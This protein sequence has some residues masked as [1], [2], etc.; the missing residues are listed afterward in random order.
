VRNLLHLV[1]VWGFV[2]NGARSYYTNRSQPPLLSPM[3]MA[4]WSAA[5]D[6]G[7]LFEALP[8]LVAQ[9]RYWNSGNKVVRVRACES[10]EGDTLRVA[11]NGPAV[12]DGCD[13]V[14]EIFML[15]RYH[16]E[17]YK[18]RPESFRCDCPL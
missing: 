8:R 2:P 11:S 1:D 6:D 17:L 7:I 15:S 12:Q 3:V 10:R 4:V 5:G 18:P 16:A 13:S 14:P 9:H